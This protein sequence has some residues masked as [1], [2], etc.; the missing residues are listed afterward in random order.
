MALNGSPRKLVPLPSSED[1]KHRSDPSSSSVTK[2]VFFCGV[3]V[4]GSEGGRRLPEEIQELV[5]SLGD[6]LEGSESENGMLSSTSNGSSTQTDGATTRKRALTDTSALTSALNELVATERSYVQRL[7]ILKK[8][9]ADPLRN[10]ARSK[11]T[12]IL[13]KYEATTLFGNVDNLLPVNEAFLTDLEK[14]VA[15]NGAKTVGGI[16]DVALRHFKGLRGFELYKQYYVKRE[17]AQLIFEREVSKRSSFAAYIDRIK[18]QSSDTKNRIGLRELLMDPVQRIPRYTLLFRLM[19]KYMAT[20]DP[21]RAKL[22]EADEIASKIAQAE[23]DEQT[24][25]VSIF[26][27]LIANIE[28][29]PPDL[30]SNSRKFIDCI[31]VEEIPTDMPLASSASASSSNLSSLHCTLFLF[32]DKVLLVKRPGNGEKSGRSLAGLDNLDKVA[33]SLKLISKSMNPR[34]ARWSNSSSHGGGA[35]PQARS[36]SVFQLK[37]PSNAAFGE[38]ARVQSRFNSSGQ[39]TKG[40]VFSELEFTLGQ[41]ERELQ[42]NPADT[43]AQ[44][45]VA[46]LQQL[47]R[48]VEAGVSQ[49]ELVQILGQLRSLMRTATQPSPPPPPQHQPQP[50]AAP[51][52]PAPATFTTPPPVIP[53]IP[54]V[55]S[56]PPPLKTELSTSSSMS[57]I[58]PPVPAAGFADFLSSLLKSG[59]VSA[60][61]TPLGVGSTQAEEAIDYERETSR[62]YCTGIL[63]HSVQ[64]STV[65]LMGSKPPMQS[66]L[67]DR[68]SLQCKQRG[69][70][71]LDTTSGKKELEDRLDMHFRQNLKANQ[72]IGRRRG[73]SWFIRV[74]DW[75]HNV[76]D[77]V[78]NGHADH[79][80]LNPKA[81]A[82]VE[83][84]KWD[85]EL[86]SHFVV[87]PPGNESTT[88]SCPVCKE[89]LSPGFV[90]DCEKW[91]WKNATKK[92][93]RICRATC[94]A[95]A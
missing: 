25:R 20:D 85:A 51:S 65:G 69:I 92:D 60:N 90:K 72:N 18:Y 38:K 67:Y 54:T 32:D 29:F 64:L 10:F 84:I 44:N 33:N 8:D 68:L 89:I 3:V 74:K 63:D 5:L 34:A 58:S 62:S 12:A 11:S 77:V 70:R 78:G 23:T 35:L 73:R 93:D 75:I 37:S 81:A 30:F 4:E 43:V 49:E 27:C 15:P 9:Y 57:A 53:S 61:G 26:Y 86:R 91:V 36:Y 46:V 87:V 24:Q 45:H 40:Q 42:C 82:A 1:I 13:P 31:D 94:H 48:L 14:M 50:V 76:P 47:R 59:V 39:V 7:Q 2:R 41:K 22:M 55:Q 88:I 17:E 79:R 71:F 66:L 80:P 21:Q 52:W 56:L 19:I 6:V 83:A 16:G 28:G 95:E